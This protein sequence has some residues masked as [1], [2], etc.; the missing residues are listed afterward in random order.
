MADIKTI[1]GAIDHLDAYQRVNSTHLL[2]LYVG[3]DDTA[4][5]TL[6]MISEYPP[7]KVASSRMIL[8]KSGRRPDKKWSLSFSLVDDNYKDMFVLFCED[9][10]LS[11]S[12]IKNKDKATR[13]VGKRYMEWREML[14]NARGNLLSPAE[15]KGLL[16]EMYFLKEHLCAQYGAEKAALSWT[17]PKQLPQDYIIDDTWYE[18]KTVSSSRTEVSISSIEQ[19][20][21]AKPGEL[22][23][24]R[25]DKTSVTN[26]AAVNL[27]ILYKELLAMLPDDDSRD[28]FSTMLL[29]YGYYP[30][31]E[32]EGEEYTF[33]IKTIARYAVNAD[34]PCIRRTNL[35]ESISEAK[36]SLALA[37]IESYRKE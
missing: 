31:P 13:F 35:P 15:V 18:V 26:T 25:A 11:S 27:N 30:R 36:Y 3:I 34:F 21:C 20:D 28:K 6:L 23:V 5:W 2:D 16:G 19:L 10:V 4:R 9:I 7:L 17:G 14:A 1:F 37:A 22:V 24:I 32:Y 12:C 29:R 33:E 8:V